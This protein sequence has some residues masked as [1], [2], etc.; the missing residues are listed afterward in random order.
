MRTSII[1]LTK[2]A[3]NEFEKLLDAVFSQS[4]KDFEV[5]LIDSGSTDK[6]LEIAK[7]FPVR[8]H[9]IKPESFDHGGTRNLGAKLAKGKYLVYLTQDAIPA[10]RMWLENLIKP[11][12]N[13]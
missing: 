7:G 1:I 12:K 11:L 13:K 2:N 4:S 8:I 9:K 5:V 10:N 6:T 3:G